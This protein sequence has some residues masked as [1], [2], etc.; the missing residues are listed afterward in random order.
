MKITFT[1]PLANDPV[2]ITVA[3]LFDVTVYHTCDSN[4]FTLTDQSNISYT[5]P[6]GITDANS[7]TTVVAKTT[8]NNANSDSNC[9]LSYRTE[10]WDA[11]TNNWT[12]MTNGLANASPR[13]L[14]IQA[15]S[16]SDTTGAG[17]SKHYLSNTFTLYLPYSN[18]ANYVTNW[19]TTKPK[20]RSKVF[21][22]V[23]RTVYDEYE[24]T[25]DY[26]CWHDSV[27]MAT[28]NDL[29]YQ[30]GSGSVALT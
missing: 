30:F 22:V 21:D 19:G 28:L 24:I 29:T 2:A 12:E 9:W 6:A 11:T 14:F 25:F 26:V 7:P 5:V 10:F 13:G 8:V 15:N 3:A 27:T 23:G 20:F 4:P 18:L 16:Y 17:G 1:D